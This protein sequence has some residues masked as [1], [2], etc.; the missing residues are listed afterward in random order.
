M[1]DA[2]PDLKGERLSA[3]VPLAAYLAPF[4]MHYFELVQPFLS[5]DHS[6]FRG[7]GVL[8]LPAS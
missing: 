3:S 5:R 6:P 2:I 7:D 1:C 4:V 8:P